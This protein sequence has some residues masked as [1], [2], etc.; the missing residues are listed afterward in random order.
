MG[1]L[2]GEV[3]TH[4]SEGQ[5]TEGPPRLR[6]AVRLPNGLPSLYPGQRDLSRRLHTRRGAR[7]PILSFCTCHVHVCVRRLHPPRVRLA[8][9]VVC[10]VSEITS[11]VKS[12][13]H[14]ADPQLRR[15]PNPAQLAVIAGGRRA[16]FS[17]PRC[18]LLRAAA[19]ESHAESPFGL[20][21]G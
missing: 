13:R 11:Q 20:A 15:P 2:S 18:A 8:M 9:S 21:V 10:R 7:P 14:V 17:P 6:R 3:N 5:S 1:A 19:S 16:D 12:S 4:P